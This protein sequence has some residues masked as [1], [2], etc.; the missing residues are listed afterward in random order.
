MYP[1]LRSN[2]WYR[3]PTLAAKMLD[4][5]WNV[6]C[7]A[8]VPND[9]PGKGVLP[10]GTERTC[11]ESPCNL[12]IGLLVAVRVEFF[13]TFYEAPKG[14]YL[15][16]LVEESAAVGGLLAVWLAKLEV[17]LGSGLVAHPDF[18]PFPLIPGKSGKSVQLL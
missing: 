4:V 17:Q 6:I 13:D 7:V 12:S 8:N 14:A 11:V 2:F 10:A 16:L 3:E 18:L 1:H 15:R 5:G 9:Q